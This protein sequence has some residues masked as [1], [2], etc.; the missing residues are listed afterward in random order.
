MAKQTKAELEAAAERVKAR[1]TVQEVLER[2]G[3]KIVGNRCKSF[4]HDGQKLT[5]QISPDGTFCRCHKCNLSFDVISIT[6]HFNNNCSFSRAVKILG[7]DLA[8]TPEEK[9][10]AAK[11]KAEKEAERKKQEALDQEFRY[12][13]LMKRFSQRMM[14]A[15]P[16]K[17]GEMA[18][19]YNKSRWADMK[20]AEVMEKMPF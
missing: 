6:Q 19:Y 16:E 3:V 17:S 14:Y 8:M 20:L 5:T 7:G 9:A 1:H 13:L 4:C 10:M 11:L 18:H 12:W 2:Y 15:A